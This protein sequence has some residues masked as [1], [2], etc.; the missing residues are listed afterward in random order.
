LR[1][2]LGDYFKRNNLSKNL[3]IDI[4]KDALSQAIESSREFA[5]SV[6][7]EMHKILNSTRLIS[8]QN[9]VNENS[10]TDVHTLYQECSKKNFT[11]NAFATEINGEKVI[12]LCPGEIIG[13]V[14]FSRENQIPEK[15]KLL[16]LVMTLGHELSHHFDYRF[17]PDAYKSTKES[18]KNFNSKLHGPIEN[19]MSEISADMWGLKVAKIIISKLGDDRLQSK[20]YSGSLDD[21]CGAEDDG[22]HP[23]AEYRIQLLAGNLLCR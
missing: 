22:E 20:V 12:I 14:E 16:P 21:L 13:A 23:D 18:L 1:S 2:E 7:V 19:Y 15:F 10:L 6:K 5:T 11:D 9:D 4:I 8:F 3:E 17:F